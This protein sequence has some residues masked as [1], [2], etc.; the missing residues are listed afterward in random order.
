MDIYTELRGSQNNLTVLGECGVGAGSRRP[1][2]WPFKAFQISSPQDP[3]RVW[4]SPCG[5]AFTESI[6]APSSTLVEKQDDRAVVV[7]GKSFRSR[8]WNTS[9][10]D[11]VREPWTAP[12]NSSSH[13]YGKTE[14]LSR[15]PD[16]V[17]EHGEGKSWGQHQQTVQS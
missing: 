8:Q 17:K 12:F 16:N 1:C 15:R 2:T 5:R 9:Q 3:G 11:R 7:P 4:V 6:E 13:K 14:A 10:R